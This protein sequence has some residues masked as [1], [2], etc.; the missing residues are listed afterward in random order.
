MLRELQVTKDKPANSMYKAGEEKIITGMAVVKNETDKKFEFVAAETATDLFFVDKERIP[1]G[2]NAAR[3]DMSDYDQ[4]FTELEEGEFGKL[5][6]YLP[7][8]R[9]A[10]DQ[11]KDSLTVGDRVSADVDGKLKKATATTVLS[12]YIYKGEFNDNGHKLAIIEVSDAAVAN[13]E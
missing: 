5:I 4:N 8:E 1:T 7:G 9:F 3:G 11:F 13:A 10:T 6:T 2:L 12:K